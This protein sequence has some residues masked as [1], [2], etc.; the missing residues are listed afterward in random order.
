MIGIEIPVEEWLNNY[1]D[2]YVDDKDTWLKFRPFFTNIAKDS[3]GAEVGTFEGYNALG[4]CRYCSPKKLY[5]I[6]PYKVYDSMSDTCIWKQPDWENIFERTKQKFKDYPVEFIR[7]SSVEGVK[8]APD[9][10]DWVYIDGDHSTKSVLEDIETW[11]PKVKQG[12]QIG[13]H[14]VI[15]TEVLDAIAIW[16][17]N[18]RKE[19]AVFK[20]KWNDWWVTK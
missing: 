1:P 6:D 10:L 14:D 15:E 5:L 19:G 9:N 7:K 4:I 8:D 17:Y 2:H 13:G 12:G 11:F 16:F 18:N 3:I 20:S